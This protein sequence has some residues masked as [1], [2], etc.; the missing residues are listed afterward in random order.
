MIAHIHRVSLE[1]VKELYEIRI[2]ENDEDVK[3]CMELETDYQGCKLIRVKHDGTA[4]AS[5]LHGLYGR[6]IFKQ[7]RDFLWDECNVDLIQW[8]GDGQVR[9]L[10]K[11]RKR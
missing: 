2:F 5:L 10:T 6:P 11:R 1:D 9:N 7:V 3:D 4:W 8:S